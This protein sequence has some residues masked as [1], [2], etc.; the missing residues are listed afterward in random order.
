MCGFGRVTHVGGKGVK[1]IGGGGGNL[2][3]DAIAIKASAFHDQ[4][5]SRR[6]NGPHATGKM[7]HQGM[8]EGCRVIVGDHLL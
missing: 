5:I 4:F 6:P 7:T 8:L 2:F 1:E 3:E